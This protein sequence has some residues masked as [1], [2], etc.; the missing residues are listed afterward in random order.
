[1]NRRSFERHLARVEAD[2]TEWL[3]ACE[4]MPA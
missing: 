2:I 1:M 4:E 3:A